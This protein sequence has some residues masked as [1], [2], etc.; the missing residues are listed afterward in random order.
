MEDFET[1]RLA[2]AA[3]CGPKEGDVFKNNDDRGSYKVNL[4]AVRVPV[5]NA[6]A[7]ETMDIPI[8]RIKCRKSGQTVFS[9][10]ANTAYWTMP[11]GH[12]WETMEEAEVVPMVPER[13]E[14]VKPKTKRKKPEGFGEF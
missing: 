4:C 1:V 3:K 6:S 13:E 8:M 10:L 14:E 7:G 11:K 12:E 5:L 2:Y 9:S